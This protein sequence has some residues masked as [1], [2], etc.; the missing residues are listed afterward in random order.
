MPSEQLGNY[1]IGEME[2]TNEVP[3]RI[4]LQPARPADQRQFSPQGK[5]ALFGRPKQK[6]LEPVQVEDFFVTTGTTS[7]GVP[8]I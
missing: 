8:I 6:V 2:D 5:T 1:L 3:L 4:L 7:C